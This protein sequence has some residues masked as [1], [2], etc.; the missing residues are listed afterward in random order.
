LWFWLLRVRV[1][2]VTPFAHSCVRFLLSARWLAVPNPLFILL[3]LLLVWRGAFAEVWSVESREPISAPRGLSAAK[4]A[5]RSD[6]VRGELH[7][8]T[9]A[10]STHTLALMD[11]PENVYDLASAARKRGAVAAVNGG[12]FHPDRTPLGLRVRMGKE[13]HPIERARLLS[14]LLT[15][16]ADRIALLRVGEFHRSPGLRE[17]VQAGPFLVDSGKPVAGLNAT[18]SAARTAILE[19]AGKRHG[20]VITSRLTL[21]EAGA[22]LATPG[23]IPGIKIVRA[24][25]L[26]GG[27]S[28]GMW[29]DSDPPHYRRELRDVRDFVGIVPR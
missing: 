2:S 12:Y 15:V 25:N 20:L 8:V 22:V 29:I 11:D 28:T 7:S 17:A 9:F 13:I 27:S 4:I 5:V 24:L 18:R 3:P 14:G 16:T 26:D 1:P 19:G 21:A 6:S 23:L 10:A